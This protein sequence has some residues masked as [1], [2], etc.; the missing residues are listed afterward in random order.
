MTEL[1]AALGFIQMQ[2][3]E[4]LLV[5]RQRVADWYAERLAEIPQVEPPQLVPSTTRVSWFVYVIRLSRDINRDAFANTL[6]QKGIPVRPYFS[7]I[8][9][10]PYMVER[11]NYQAGDFPVTEDLANRGLA[12][13]FS[14]K[15]TEAQVET[16]CQS[17]RQAVQESI[18]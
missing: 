6:S 14:G 1:S 2:R 4:E 3:I 15:M 5:K 10:Q 11:F 12:L 7:P 13:P 9:L 17:V 18:R 8:H 16:V